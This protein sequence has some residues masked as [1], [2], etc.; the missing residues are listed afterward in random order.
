VSFYILP[1]SFTIKPKASHILHKY[2]LYIYTSSLGTG[3]LT[4]LLII[5]VAYNVNIHLI[6]FFKNFVCF[7]RNS[8]L[9][10]LMYECSAAYTFTCQQRASD[11]PIGG[12]QLPCGCWELTSEPLEEQ[13]V[14]FFVCLV[15]FW[16]VFLFFC[17][18][19]CFSRQG[20]SV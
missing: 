15:W 13:T 5:P 1:G 19:V 6:F 20:F 18:F 7:Q 4:H 17:L 16:V 10:Y 11:P 8:V 2:S 14:F 9:F 12:C 3:I